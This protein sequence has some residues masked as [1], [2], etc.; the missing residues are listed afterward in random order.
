MTTGPSLTANKIT[1]VAG[2]T[3]QLTQLFTFNQG[4]DP[5]VTGAEV[6]FIDPPSYLS[7]GGATEINAGNGSYYAYSLFGPN[8]WAP[9]GG[10]WSSGTITLGSNES[11]APSGAF[12]IDL[13]FGYLGPNYS[14]SFYPG[15]QNYIF[16]VSLTPPSVTITA[17]QPTVEVNENVLDQL[18]P[19]ATFTISLSEPLSSAVT[20]EYSTADG[21]ANADDD[22]LPR[23]GSVTIAAGKTSATVRVPTISD[24]LFTQGGESF[25]VSPVFPR[26]VDKTSQFFGYASSGDNYINSHQIRRLEWNGDTDFLHWHLPADGNQMSCTRFC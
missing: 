2:E 17:D 5:S 16:N 25:S 22:Y 15:P 4:N 14:G 1:L 20:V 19:I 23:S 10:L 7:F 8:E 26:L 6:E 12:E 13:D 9:Q 18:G 24:G 11:S 3:Y 21:T